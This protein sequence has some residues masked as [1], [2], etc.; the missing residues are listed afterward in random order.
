MSSDAGGVDIDENGDIMFLT[1]QSNT[2]PLDIV[3]WEVRNEIQLN[4]YYVTTV[5]KDHLDPRAAF[6]QQIVIIVYENDLKIKT[7]CR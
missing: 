1:R 3:T 2:I 4:L 6:S 7:T 5:Y